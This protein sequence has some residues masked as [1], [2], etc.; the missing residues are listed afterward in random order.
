MVTVKI[1]IKTDA[2]V[3]PA[4]QGLNPL[5]CGCR[6]QLSA[7]FAA[8]ACGWLVAVFVLENSSI[9]IEIAAMLANGL[10][11]YE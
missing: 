1:S 9:S 6:G 8:C 3:K 7:P 10:A 11:T 4:T 5:W 2:F